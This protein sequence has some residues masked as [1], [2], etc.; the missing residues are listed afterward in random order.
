MSAG[1][2][3]SNDSGNGG[4]D[5]TPASARSGEIQPSDWSPL[6]RH[7]HKPTAE[8]VKKTKKKKRLQR[9]MGG[10]LWIQKE[11]AE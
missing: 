5:N 3:E 11:D 1:G 6:H 7:A 8:D 4:G 10:L 9:R 2:D